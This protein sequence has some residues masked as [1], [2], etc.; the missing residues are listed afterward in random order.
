MIRDGKI[1][2]ALKVGNVDYNLGHVEGTD[3]LR[4]PVSGFKPSL[5]IREANFQRE[6]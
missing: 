4:G 6:K 2:V 3:S 5:M 1:K